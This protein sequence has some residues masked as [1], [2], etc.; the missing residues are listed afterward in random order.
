[1]AYSDT[2]KAIKNSIEQTNTMTL[3]DMTDLIDAVICLLEKAEKKEG[4]QNE[5]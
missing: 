3:R 4:G 5:P 1:M 2:L